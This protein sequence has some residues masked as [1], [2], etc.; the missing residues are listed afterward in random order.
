MTSGFD[1]FS[2]ALFTTLSPA[3]VIAFICAAIPILFFRLDDKD[4]SRLNHYLAVPCAVV[5]IGFIASATHLGTPSNALYVFTGVGRSPLSNEVFCVV[6][7]LIAAGSQ[8]MFSFK[9]DAPRILSRSWLA[10][11]CVAGVAFIV[12]TSL[13]YA[14]DTVPTWNSFITPLNLWLAALFAG[15]VLGILVGTL[16]NVKM[17]GY[18]RVLSILASIGFIVGLGFLAA[19]QKSLPAISNNEFSAIELLPHYPAVI[20]GYIL[21]GCVG[22][23]LV[24]YAHRQKPSRRK[25]LLYLTLACIFIFLAVFIPRIAFYKLHMTVGF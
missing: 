23:S 2:L 6:L 1:N 17:S 21:F 12:M 19:T 16:A 3:G 22:L 4:S 24:V 9:R 20:L 14:V 5:L 10:I 11:S 18:S 13:A 25:V 15:P 8:W 7:F